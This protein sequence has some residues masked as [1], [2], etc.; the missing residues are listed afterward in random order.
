MFSWNNPGARDAP[1]PRSSQM[2]SLYV[3]GA[4]W[5][6]GCACWYDQISQVTDVAEP[7]MIPSDG[8]TGYVLPLS[9][10]AET[11]RCVG[12]ES[13]YVKFQANVM[14]LPGAILKYDVWVCGGWVMVK[15]PAGAVWGM[16]SVDELA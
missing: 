1:G 13:R 15:P 16:L 10:T 3:P 9:H 11:V 7:G 5:R 6:D 12:V 4:S 2:D 14:V 8:P